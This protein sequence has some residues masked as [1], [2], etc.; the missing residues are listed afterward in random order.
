M[1][2]DVY[3]SGT[4][5]LVTA[6]SLTLYRLFS[7]AAEKVVQSKDLHSSEM[8]RS[9]EWQ[10]CTTFRDNLYI[11]F[12]RAKQSEKNFLHNLKGAYN[13]YIEA[14]AGKKTHSV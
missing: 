2:L 6:I 4:S 1:R 12:S 7:T 9:V 11:Q 8:L 10:F 14:E 5:F 3:F 13:I